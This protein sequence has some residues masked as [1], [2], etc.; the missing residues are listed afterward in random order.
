M[1][2]PEVSS[3]SAARRNEQKLSAADLLPIKKFIQQFRTEIDGQIS[4]NQPVSEL[5]ICTAWENLEILRTRKKQFGQIIPANLGVHYLGELL[6]RAEAN[7]ADIRAARRQ[8]SESVVIETDDL[9]PL[10]RQIRNIE[11][12]RSL[13]WAA[14]IFWQL[15]KWAEAEEEGSRP[16]GVSDHLLLTLYAL[17]A[18]VRE[19]LARGRADEYQK[20]LFNGIGGFI[21]RAES[22]VNTSGHKIESG[23]WEKYGETEIDGLRHLFK[24][25][26]DHL[27]LQLDGGKRPT[28]ANLHAL[29]GVVLATQEMELAISTEDDGEDKPSA[30]M[31]AELAQLGKLR[32]IREITSQDQVSEVARIAPN[33]PGKPEP[34]SAQKSTPELESLRRYEPGYLLRDLFGTIDSVNS[35]GL[36]EDAIN[37]L[38]ALNRTYLDNHT[39]PSEHLLALYALL[40]SRVEYV[41]R[42][43]EDED[44]EQLE[45]LLRRIDS[46]C[47]TLLLSRMRAQWQDGFAELDHDF[48]T[49]ESFSQAYEL[50]AALSRYVHMLIE[51]DEYD[52]SFTMYYWSALND[53]VGRVLVLTKML[54]QADSGMRLSNLLK[55]YF[56]TVILWLKELRSDEVSSE[57][58][59]DL[60]TRL[61]DLR[62]AFPQDAVV[63]DGPS[64]GDNEL[65]QDLKQMAREAGANF[66]QPLKEAW[67][68]LA[69]V[70]KPRLRRVEG[71]DKQAD[72]QTTEQPPSSDTLTLTFQNVKD[73][74]AELGASVEKKVADDEL[75]TQA[76]HDRLA[77]LLK[78]ISDQMGD[79]DGRKSYEP[80]MKQV[81]ELLDKIKEHNEKLLASRAGKS[82]SE[83]PAD[84]HN[85]EATAHG[86][87]NPNEPAKKRFSV[88][89]TLNTQTDRTLLRAYKLLQGVLKNRGIVLSDSD[90]NLTEA[91]V[92]ALT[93]MKQ[94]ETEAVNFNID[95]SFEHP[96]SSPMQVDRRT[97]VAPSTLTP[98]PPASDVVNIPLTEEQK[99]TALKTEMKKWAREILTDYPQTVAATYLLKNDKKAAAMAVTGFPLVKALAKKSTAADELEV[100]W[101]ELVGKPW[102]E[103]E[104]LRQEERER[105]ALAITMVGQYAEHG[106]TAHIKARMNNIR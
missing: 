102:G 66:G 48:A 67:A 59:S 6:E 79:G 56:D 65:L 4:K 86:G 64:G 20:A 53:L 96:Q 90:D 10:N 58:A 34:E 8:K 80:V 32:A 43:V 28:Q 24:I 22:G 41:K 5:S 31:K 3:Q 11:Q 35:L 15:R 29:N 76:E 71:V 14:I 37:S 54:D 25:G 57:T 7:N 23:D 94:V 74:V 85:D 19:L 82:T 13:D 44:R 95:E 73:Q 101:R 38:E 27:V 88:K 2:A 42:A 100:A 50:F 61:S 93:V 46:N 63:T 89:E 97:D 81:V 16:G 106:K 99:A 26:R 21:Q 72:A 40:S 62:E 92:G 75:F 103:R 30:Q 33:P 9:P 12:L 17:E 77:N 83:V 55:A 52:G 49:V 60:E 78:V 47:H 45:E 51:H 18:R 84:A 70:K 91:E 68:L 69:K 104:S 105:V 1:N 98:R 39:S 87:D 36:A